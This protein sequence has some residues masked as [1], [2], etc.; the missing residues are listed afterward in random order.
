MQPLVLTRSY[1]AS[2]IVLVLIVGIIHTGMAYLLYFTAIK[3]LRG[4]TIAVLSYLDPISAVIM[5]AIILGET[6]NFAQVVGGVLV[7]GSAFLSEKWK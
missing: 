5:A 4:Q 1:N 2:S 6:L 3:D 7:L